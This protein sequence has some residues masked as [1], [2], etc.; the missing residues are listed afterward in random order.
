M[1]RASWLELALIG[2]LIVLCFVLPFSV[3]TNIDAWYGSLLFWCL[4]S[5]L[6]IGLCA[7]ISARWKD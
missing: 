6:V 1:Q 5:L 4:A 3:F 7:R 2:I